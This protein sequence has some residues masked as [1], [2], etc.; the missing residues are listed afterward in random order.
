M[1]T[2]E[3]PESIDDF[4]ASCKDA[5]D[6]FL[7]T[8][9]EAETREPYRTLAE[10]MRYSL[11]AG[12]KRVR[13]ILA[14]A[15]LEALGKDPH[16]F[17][18][19][20]ASLEL[21]H[22]YSLIHDDL[23]SMDNDALRR[24]KPTNHVIYGDATAILAGDALLTHA[25]TL[26]S[27]PDYD[28]LLPPEN[29]IRIVWELSSASGINGMVG[30]QQ[31]DIASEGKAL[32]LEGLEFLH[33]HKTGALIRSAVR[34]G[35]HLGE[36]DAASFSALD[37]YGIA[38]GIAFQIADDLLDVEGDAAML[39]KAAHKDQDRNKNTYP[40]LLGIEGARSMAKAKLEDAL[41]SIE[42]FGDQGMHLRDLARYIIERRN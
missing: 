3:T 21:I 29:R 1:I 26:L 37:R 5:I 27:A 31:L 34:I 16:P 7:S 18:P 9:F 36:A 38:V 41:S 30:G 12:G 39:G 24:G 25:F 35:G 19:F 11:L 10:S 2:S 40:G 28:N 22:T 33:R 23:P 20:L 6:R 15:A 14:M 17:V 13:P 8:L 42:R 32:D 4:L